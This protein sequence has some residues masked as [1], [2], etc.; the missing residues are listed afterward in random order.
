MGFVNLLPKTENITGADCTGN[1]GDSNRT[2]TL[3]NTP[4]DS[5]GIDLVVDG[6]YL[7]QGSGKDFTFSAGIITF[8]NPLYDDSNIGINYF[9]QISSSDFVPSSTSLKYITPAQFSESLGMKADIPSWD[10]GETPSKELVG[11]GDGSSSVFYLDHRYIISDTYNLYCGASEAAATLLTETTDYVLDKDTGKITLTAGGITTVDSN[12]IYAEYSHNSSGM[13]DSY[14]SSVLARAEQ[15]V[16]DTLNTTFTDGTTD[17][18]DYPVVALE[19]LE[20][21]GNT[22]NRYFTKNRPL[23]DVNSLLATALDVDDTSVEVTAGEGSNFPESGSI[24]IGTE[25]MTYTG[26]STDTLTGVTRGADGSTAA[27]HSVGDEIHTTI[28]QISGTQEG[29]SPTWSVQE[30]KKSVYVEDLGQI[31]LY[32]PLLYGEDDSENELLS[33]VGV[34]NR[35]KARY[36]YGY[37]TIPQSITRLTFLFAKRMLMQDNIGKSI[38]AGRDEF[39]PEMFNADLEEMERIINKYLQYSI[40]TT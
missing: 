32:N 31:F 27:A 19:S 2:Y 9:Q 29:T 15:E 4:V 6:S 28:I 12:N 3:L 8:L 30:W 39:K 18:P 24:I 7:H 40:S 17:N 35:L 13:K 5:G 10:V 20:S 21:L 33:Q 22:Q 26:I 36:L 37:T 16:D 34:A 11:T 1:D 14:V 23:I 25:I 38:I